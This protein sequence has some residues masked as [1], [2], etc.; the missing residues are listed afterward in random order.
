M[1]FHRRATSTVKASC[2]AGGHSESTG[3]KPPAPR[4]TWWSSQ[5]VQA[6]ATAR[7]TVASGEPMRRSRAVTSGSSPGRYPS[8]WPQ[9]VSTRTAWASGWIRPTPSLSHVTSSAEVV[10]TAASDTASTRPGCACA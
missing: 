2:S 3:V 6:A 10:V 8:G 5:S 7:R 9:S 4:D 1:W